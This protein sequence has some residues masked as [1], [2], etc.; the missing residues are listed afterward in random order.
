MLKSVTYFTPKRFV[1]RSESRLDM[2]VPTEMTIVTTPA[3][4]SGTPKNSC[5]TGQPAPSRES[6]RP[7]EMNAR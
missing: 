3:Q 4:A 6:G 5:I 2:T 1:S 7:S